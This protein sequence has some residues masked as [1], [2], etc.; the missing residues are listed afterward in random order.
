MLK[1]LDYTG[2]N[3]LFFKFV[4]IF[5]HEFTRINNRLI[6]VQSRELAAKLCINKFKLQCTKS[7]RPLK[8]KNQA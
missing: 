5:S 7:P 6:R 4:D 8:V 2:L 3:A 1:N